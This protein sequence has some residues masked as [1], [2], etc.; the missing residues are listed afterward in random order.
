MKDGKSIMTDKGFDII[1]H[2]ADHQKETGKTI[3]LLIPPFKRRGRGQG[4]KFTKQDITTSRL[5]AHHRI[6]VE[7]TIGWLKKWKVLQGNINFELLPV[8]RQLLKIICF[9]TNLKH[10]VSVMC[11]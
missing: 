2:L 5:V 10:Y 9:L 11:K 8:F 3:S 4:F 1:D 7:N 6:I